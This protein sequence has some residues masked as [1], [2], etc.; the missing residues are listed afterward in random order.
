[1]KIGIIG[2]VDHGKTTLTEAIL[3]FKELGHDVVIAAEKERGITIEE[4]IK[5]DNSLMLNSLRYNEVV[6]ET[7]KSGRE[8]RR[9]RRKQE[10]KK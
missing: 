7:F 8:S 3:R 4:S 6:Q 2:H 10:R 9:E 1:M 5:L